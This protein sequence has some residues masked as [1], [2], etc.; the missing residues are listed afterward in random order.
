M[1]RWLHGEFEGATI[2]NVVRY[3]STGFGI[4]SRFA[5]WVGLN[6][7]SWSIY[8]TATGK[9][10]EVCLSYVPWDNFY[11]RLTKGEVATGIPTT[12]SIDPQNKVALY[13]TPDKAYKVRGRH[14][15]D[16]QS[17]T[18]DADVPEMPAR[19]HDAIKWRALVLLATF[20]E[21]FAQ[22]QNWDA[23]YQPRL[24]A[25]RHDQLPRISMPGPLV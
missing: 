21:S 2:S 1:W 19:F 3:E 8:D 10:G 14:Y 9:D 20:D 22:I 18:G 6:S 12:F 4:A 5:H 7:T 17:L 11:T 24:S 16:N 25:L 23:F 13:P 15:K